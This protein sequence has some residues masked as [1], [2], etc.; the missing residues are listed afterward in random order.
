[1]HARQAR[2][3]VVRAGDGQGGE[4]IE[5]GGPHAHTRLALARHRIGQLTD[6][7]L[8][9]RAVA[10]AENSLHGASAVSGPDRTRAR[11]VPTESEGALDSLF[12]AYFLSANRR[13]P[14]IKSGAGFRR[15][16]RSAVYERPS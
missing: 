11:S 12:G 16:M 5:R 1:G 8:I 9:G 3:G 14:R 13:P 2:R 4:K 10:G 6:L 15:N 7:E